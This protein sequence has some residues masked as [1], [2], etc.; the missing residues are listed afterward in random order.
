MAVINTAIRGEFRNGRYAKYS[1][2][3]PESAAITIADNNAG[4]KLKCR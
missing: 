3:T 4:T 1:I 2:K